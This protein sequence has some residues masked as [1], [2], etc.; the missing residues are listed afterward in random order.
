M[1]EVTQCPVCMSTLKEPKTLPCLHSCCKDCLDLVISKGK[2]M[3]TSLK[4][5]SYL[6]H[7]PCAHSQDHLLFLFLN[8]FLCVCVF[9]PSSK[10][11]T[12]EVSTVP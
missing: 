3:L 12:I 5:A 4:T 2:N 9:L 6:P 7:E 1:E 10:K 11:T 8:F